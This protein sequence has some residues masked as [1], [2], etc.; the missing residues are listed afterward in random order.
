[1]KE[2]NYPFDAQTLIRKKKR[3]KRELLNS[4]QNFISKKIA[5]L[6][7]STTAEVVDQLELFLLNYGIKPTFYQSEYGKF[8][9]DAV[10]GN[11]ELDSFNPDL[12]YIHTNWHNITA[13]P[14]VADS[15][16]D[17]QTLQDNEYARLE[18][19]WDKLAEKFGCPIIQNNFDRPNIRLL[20]NRDI[21]DIHGKANFIFNLN[22]EMYGYA[23]NHPNFFI[24]DL[25]YISSQYGLD[26]FNDR[27]IWAMYKYCCPIEAIP[28]IAHSVATIIK[29]IYG[30]NKKVVVCD[31]DNTLWGGVVGDDGAAGIKIGQEDPKGQIFW[32]FQNYL[33]D[34]ESMGVLLAVNS[35]NDY[36][37]AIEGLN[38]PEG[39][40]KEG[41]FVAIKANWQ[42]KDQNMSELAS[43]L[44]LGIDSF[45]F[46]DDNPV[47]REL[48][49]N[50]NCGIAVPDLDQPENYIKTIDHNG[51][52][53]ATA[54]TDD[55]LTR[56]KMYHSNAKRKS[57]EQISSSYEDFLDN[58]QMKALIHPFEPLYIERIAQLTNKS[59]QFNLTT[60]RYSEED[61]KTMAN[62]KNHICLYA[63]LED[64]YGDNGVVSVVIGE[65]DGGNL[66]IKLWLMSCRVLKRELEYA[67]LDELVR[68]ATQTG[69]NKITG[70]YYPTAK[71]SMVKN[72]YGDF[73]FTKVS[74]RDGNTVWE[75]DISNY[76][77][78]N[79]H[80]SVS[81]EH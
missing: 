66:N 51:Y 53:E 50:L 15:A 45:V 20:G 39:V 68:K 57:L 35:K 14:A 72:L 79:K 36:G 64:K 11:S 29:S 48:I 8:W 47:E 71:N 22:R 41:D 75:L 33:K 3:L 40:L 70:Y 78:K 12:V 4:N 59:N 55:D 52:F 32:S 31:L 16:E 65:K 30:K 46:A 21:Y 81:T 34:L 49:D 28:L 19:M 5:V 42:N 77:P 9:E 62:S 38:H 17:V 26:G 61:I 56:T 43:E 6:G 69:I 44:N 37:N 67:V 24:N 73:G 58:L 13:F 1:M 7:G 63:K 25:D 2:F 76:T 80:I 74:D 54:I 27:Q 10:Y 23:Q 18:V 60:R